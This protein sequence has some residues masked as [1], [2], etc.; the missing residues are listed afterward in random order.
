M[1]IF[2]YSVFIMS[3]ATATTTTP[4]VTAVYYGTSSLIMTVTMAPTL[5]GLSAALG[6]H[7]L[8]LPPPLILRDTRGVVV[9]PL[10]YSS[11]LSPICLLR[12]MPIMLWILYRYISLSELYS[13]QFAYMCWCL[14]WCMLSALR[15]HAGWHIHLWE[16]NHF[17]LL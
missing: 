16:L 10:C 5:M 1:V 17:A 15:C 12:H 3:P 2:L 9:S 11:D 7:D 8:V 14:L 4:S 6:Q 13:H